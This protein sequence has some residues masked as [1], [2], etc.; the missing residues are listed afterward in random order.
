MVM[1]LS[2]EG[3]NVIVVP[4]PSQAADALQ[5]SFSDART[6]LENDTEWA[7]VTYGLESADLTFAGELLSAAQLKACAH[8][9]PQLE[10]G[11]GLIHELGDGTTLP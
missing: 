8:F 4:Y 1:Q 10:D 11:K 3:Y 7:L 9:C 6:R 2:E 5:S